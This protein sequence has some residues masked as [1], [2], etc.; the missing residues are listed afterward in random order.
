MA[1]SSE[2]WTGKSKGKVLRKFVSHYCPFVMDDL[3]IMTGITEN[4][5][6]FMCILT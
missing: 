2:Q 3:E 1:E 5:R 6:V 4:W